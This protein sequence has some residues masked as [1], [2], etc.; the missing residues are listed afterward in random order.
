MPSTTKVHPHEVFLLVR[1][2]PD[3]TLQQVRFDSGIVRRM[4]VDEPEWRPFDI[5][6]IPTPE[7]VA[8]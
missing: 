4:Q 6:S 3:G 1:R 8:R 7:G 2:L 5:D